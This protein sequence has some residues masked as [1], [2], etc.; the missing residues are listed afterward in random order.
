MFRVLLLFIFL[1]PSI[2]FSKNVL[3]FKSEDMNLEVKKISS[4]IG[5]VW[6][7]S[8]ISKNRIL[9]T[10][11][12]GK[13]GILNVKTRRIKY[14]KNTPNIFYKGQGGLLD[15]QASPAFK[16][17]NTLY[18]TYVKKVGNYAT[19]VLS[20]VNL[21]NDELKNWKEILVS[22][23]F[24]DT[25]RHFGSRITFDE[26][27]HLFFSIGDRGKRSNSQNLA[28]HSGTIIRLNLDGTIPEDNPFINKKDAL[29]EIY[30]YGHRNPQGI[31]YDK[32]TKQLLSIEHGPRGGDEIN[33][34]KKGLNY[35]WPIIS[36]G[37]EY[38]N[39]FSIGEGTHKEGMEQPLK[40]YIPSI[41]P[42]SLIVYRSKKISKWN[43]SIFSG[44][45]KL[46]HLNRIV[47]NKNNKVIKEERLLKKLGERIRNVIQSPQ[48]DLFISTDTGSIYKITKY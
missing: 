47:L 18:F 48:G 42:S 25:T 19:T 3:T 7:M 38:W 35:G 32:V 45:L 15:V 16:D 6:G 33:L 29:P 4:N 22:N 27:G 44:A 14:L 37:K 8:F 13:I 11:K 1:L 17:D 41:A 5:V 28:N 40:Y 10:V 34:I 30:T 21:I 26:K 12:S 23:A 43:G 46:R 31:F 36:Y 24:T 39:S 20:K 9:F 2:S